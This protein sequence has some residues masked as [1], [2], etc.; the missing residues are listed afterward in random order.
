M[1]ANRH[2]A[3]GRGV[4]SESDLLAR[5][6]SGDA[7]AF[8]A[9]F[10]AHYASVHRVLRRLVGDGA[11]DLAQEVFWRLYRNPP[12]AEDAR[13]GA[14]LYRV[15]TNL[16]YNALR[17]ASRR[18][19]YE[20]LFHRL[21]PGQDDPPDPEREALRQ[22]D[23]ARV[24]AALSRMGRKQAQILVLRH[25]GVS[26]REIARAVGVAESSVGTLLGRAERAF[27]RIYEE[28]EGRRGHDDVVP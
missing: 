27:G 1:I 26:Y 9:L 7:E 19:R 13:L 5:L 22:D 17:A 18:Q 2:L 20:E 12:A 10:E 14:W 15:A 28:L 25:S 8:R 4:A 23:G 16:G 6:R 11:D 3:A 24:R 21:W